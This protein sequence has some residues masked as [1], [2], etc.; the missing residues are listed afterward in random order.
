MSARVRGFTLL[1]LMVAMGVFTLLG[2]GATA[3]LLMGLNTWRSADSRRD[4]AER[5]ELVFAAITEDF[6][7]LY[8]DSR[9][10]AGRALLY[11]DYD[12][13]GRQRLYLTRSVPPPG[14]DPRIA[15]SGVLVMAPDGIDGV[16][17]MR[18]LDRGLLRSPG[19]LMSVTYAYTG[20]ER[21]G[22]S[23]RTP[24]AGYDRDHVASAGAPAGSQLLAEGVMHVEFNFFSAR[25]TAWQPGDGIVGPSYFWDSTMGLGSE[26]AA[27]A[28][29]K[30]RLVFSKTG[31]LADPDDDVFPRL[32][33]VKLVLSLPYA[34][35]YTFLTQDLD[36]GSASVPVEWAGAYPEGEGERF[37]KIDKEWISY[38]RIKP[39]GTGFDGVVRGRRSTR[40]AAHAAGSLVRYGL[41]FRLVVRPP[42]QRE[43]WEKHP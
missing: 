3:F 30:T 36:D 21:L 32:V 14:A 43:V 16:G 1:E 20:D 4:A 19:D 25:S 15:G 35:G 24:V 26:R 28:E 22:R 39:D 6:S 2:L 11:S 10:A 38:T 29:R 5:A 23:V 8:T 27:A 41:A 17:D 9:R 18:S 40:P 33:E 37:V 34:R 31:S 7:C 42:C 13:E 12:T